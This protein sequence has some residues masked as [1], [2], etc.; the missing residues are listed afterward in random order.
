MSGPGQ[1]PSRRDSY[2][3]SGARASGSRSNLHSGSRISFALNTTSDPSS[4]DMQQ[5]SILLNAIAGPT[6]EDPFSHA[7]SAS[8]F[9]DFLEMTNRRP[10]HHSKDSFAGSPEDNDMQSSFLAFTMSQ[11]FL[12][13][14]GEM[15]AVSRP[16]ITSAF[17]K[18]S[19]ADADMGPETTE[20]PSVSRLSPHR[21]PSR[22]S[23]TCSQVQKYIQYFKVSMLQVLN[24]KNSMKDALER[25]LKRNSVG[26]FIPVM[27][28]Y[29]CALPDGT[30]RGNFLALEMTQTF[31]KALLLNITDEKPQS[32]QMRSKVFSITENIMKSTVDQLFE[33]LAECL[34]AF[35]REV[36]TKEKSFPLGFC[37]PFACKHVSLNQCFLQKATK[38]FRWSGMEGKDVAEELQKAINQHCKNYQIEVVAVVNDTVGAMLSGCSKDTICEVGLVIVLFPC[39]G[40]LSLTLVFRYVADAGTN[41]C[42]MEQAQEIPRINEKEGRMCLNTEWGAFGSAGDLDDL[43]TEFDLLM[44]KQT[45]DPGSQRFEK[46]IGS[47]YIC[48]TVRIFL[49]NLAEKGELFNGVLTPSLL[50]RGIF[51]LQDIAEIIDEKSG[52]S[53]AKNLLLRLGMVASNQDCFYMQ[54][55][56][57]AIFYRSA[58]LCAAG[59][60]AVLTRIATAQNRPKL[61]INVAVDGVLFNNHKQYRDMLEEALKSLVPDY[62]ITFVPSHGNGALGVVMAT[63]AA[64]RQKN[65]QQQVAQV[66]APFRLSVTEL[67]RL[68]NLMRLEMIKGLKQDETATVRMLPT[69]VRHLPD[70]TERGQFLA[71]DLGGTNFRVLMVE[72][73]DPKDG[74]VHI[75]SEVYTV[76]PKIAQSSA[77]EYSYE[78]LSFLQLFDHIVSC[79]VDFQTKHKMLGIVLPL[80]FTFSFPC[81]QIG[82]DKGILLAWTKGFNAKDCVGEDAVRL[83]REAVQRQQHVDLDVVAIVNDTVG[84]MMACAYVDP[85]CEIGLIVGTGS[86]TCYMEEMKNVD[87]VE[88]NEGLMCINMEWGAF[89]DSGCLDN[90]MTSFDVRVDAE[91]LNAGHQRFEKLISGMYLGEIVRYILLELM[92]RKVLFCGQDSPMLQTKGIFPTKFLSDVEDSQ[93]EEHVCA[94]LEEFKLR[95]TAE[96]ARVVK[97]V[98]RTVSSRA[99]KFCGA[100]IAAVVEKI[101]TNRQLEKLEVTVGVDGTLYKVHPR[102]SKELHETVALLAPKCH[103]KFLLSEDGSGKGAALVAAVVPKH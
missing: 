79:I 53:K 56:C 88:G 89:G 29:V 76:P 42:Y 19:R 47:L 2:F 50:T 13:P 71:L 100:G 103:V 30:E 59:L 97:E 82:L 70:G 32:A 75:T 10:S 62:T 34:E 37:F 83:L 81:R 86:N 21:A 78:L 28:T 33:F 95:I 65:Q 25:A 23:S 52:L 51:M 96:D 1:G 60:A 38:N 101:R 69:F 5:T 39:L 74:G 84:T 43:V 16:S 8:D 26:S 80:G 102:F 6:S 61:K 27:P 40:I 94:M 48:D 4:E 36:G 41:C 63:A 68:Q 66:L 57:Q 18:V 11:S 77:T 91:S 90:F 54:K 35:L 45:M 7:L 31:V 93:G 98:C 92:S 15:H 14:S 24:V 55:L 9:T 44:D 22:I 46:L 87:A 72:L 67:E 73:K 17:L 99:A 12:Q 3:K 58:N 85:K 64:V 49:A 20:V